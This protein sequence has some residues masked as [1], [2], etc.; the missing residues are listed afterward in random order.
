M[1]DQ[2]TCRSCSYY[3]SSPRES[4]SIHHKVV[5]ERV[6]DDYTTSLWARIKSKYYLHTM[7]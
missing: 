6:C 3:N 4:C 5:F 7:E 1:V 2:K